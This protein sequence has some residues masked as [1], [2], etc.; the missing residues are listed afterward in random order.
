MNM[1]QMKTLHISQ[2]LSYLSN[3]IWTVEYWGINMINS[4]IFIY[5]HLRFIVFSKC[6][7]L[8]MCQLLNMY[9]NKCYST[10]TEYF[11]LKELQWIS[12]AVAAGWSRLCHEGRPAFNNFQ[13]CRALWW[14]LKTWADERKN[15]WKK[16]WTLCTNK[17]S[18]KE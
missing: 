7:R 12:S 15:N 2:L 4:C 8:K 3:Y 17:N 5:A 10:S 18:E 1:S 6:M 13:I 11:S 9:C 16:Y 14:P